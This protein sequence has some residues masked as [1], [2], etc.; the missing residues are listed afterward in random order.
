MSRTPIV[1][2]GAGTMGEVV[3]EYFAS[4]AYEV[5]AFAASQKYVTSPEFRGRP[6]VDIDTLENGPYRPA[7]VKLFVAI[8]YVKLNHTRARFY[9]QAKRRGYELVSYVHPSVRLW[10]SN[11]I[12]DNVFVFEDNTIQPFVRIGADTILWSGNHVGHHSRIG[13]H[14]FLASHVVVSGNCEIGEYSFLGVNATIAD[15]VTVG[16]AC[17]IGAGALIAK[18]TRDGELYAAEPTKPHKVGAARFSGLRDEEPP[19]E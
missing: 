16:R 10:A 7:A 15:G 14:C 11:E 19:R 5:V 12:G 17:L 13:A 3:D 1:V 18:S 4:S 2:V 6:L 9:E 8:G